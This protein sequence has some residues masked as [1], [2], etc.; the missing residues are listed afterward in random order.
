MR[1]LPPLTA[2]RAFEAAA[3]HKNYTRAGE[4]LGLTQ[5]GVSY[6]IKNLEQRVGT[7]LFVRQGR[8]MELT[9]AGEALAPRIAQAFAAMESAFALLGENEDSV[10]SIACFQT[11]ATNFLAPR[12]GA[13][14][15][16]NPGIAVR[17]GV[18][19]RYVDLDAGEADLAIRL[20]REATPELESHF[21]MDLGIAPFAS[22]Q[23]VARHPELQRANAAIPDEHRIS[24]GTAW[25][26][27]WDEA[28]CTV[29]GAGGAIQTRG[30]EFDSQILDAA[31]AM[32]GN[33]IAI[34]AP[35]LFASEAAAGRLQRIGTAIARPGGVFRLVYPG[36]R[37]HSPKVRAF[38]QW[39]IAEIKQHLG[40]DPDG[41]LRQH[42]P[43]A[44]A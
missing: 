40:A 4:E 25:W 18:S 1:T 14:Q 23:F 27:L 38:R 44:P 15:L 11:F 16:A 33:G 32:S 26:Q 12:L 10:L 41:L 22:P 39:L 21:L 36:V 35:A 13:F 29:R 7:L 8:S 30:L 20:S 3:R 43:S 17:I 9:L 24:T 34:L 42:P 5:A 31:A 19:N 6:Q 37:Q 28:H 2:I